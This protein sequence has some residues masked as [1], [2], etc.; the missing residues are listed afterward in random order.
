MQI[1]EHLSLPHLNSHRV[2]G[3]PQQAID[4]SLGDPGNARDAQRRK[5]SNRLQHHRLNRHRSGIV[6]GS[7]DAV[8]SSTYAH[9][10]RHKQMQASAE[11]A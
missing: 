7:I 9:V 5:S 1:H 10:M 6:S 4:L 8:S 11:A 2:S 3:S